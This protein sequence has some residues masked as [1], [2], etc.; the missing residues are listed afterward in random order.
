MQICLDPTLGGDKLCLR[1]SMVKF[2][3]SE[4]RNIEI[5][6]WASRLPM[7]LNRPLIKVLEDRGVRGLP[8]LFRYGVLTVSQ[9]TDHTFLS[10]QR[11]AVNRLRD[12]SK[13]SLLAAHFLRRRGISSPSLKLPWIFE[14][15]KSL[16]MDFWDSPFLK[17]AMELS[18]VGDLRDIKYRGRIPIKKGLTLVGV[19]DETKYLEEGEIFISTEKRNGRVKVIKGRVLITRSPVHHPGDVQMVNAISV[20]QNSPLRLLRNCVVFSQ[21]GDRPLPSKLSG[22]DLDGG[23]S[24][25]PERF[26]NN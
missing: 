25:N 18:L 7:F 2:E 12:C 10:L 3:G 9:V 16:R 6:N 13:D 22:G 5:C 17:Q 15:L 19:L 8:M 24:S 23:M 14:S 1:P 20:P 11:Q 26:S 4:D 21:K